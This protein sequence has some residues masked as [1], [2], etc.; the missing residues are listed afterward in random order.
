MSSSV[1]KT[2]RAGLVATAAML[3]VSGCA[4]PP[5][6]TTAAPV[7][8]VIQ[9]PNVVNVNQARRIL[10]SGTSA[11]AY[12][13]AVALLRPEAEKGYPDAQF[14]LG[15][16]FWEGKG[17]ER[18]PVRAVQLFE[19]ASSR[20]HV[21]AAML[22][23]A[24]YRDGTGVPRDPARAMA[25]LKVAADGGEADAAY[26]VAQAYH[27]GAGLRQDP[28]EAARYYEMAAEH[29]IIP[30]VVYVA[31][32]Y[33]TGNG[34]ELDPVWALRW[35]ERAANFGIVDSQVKFGRMIWSGEGLPV[36]QSEGM[37][38]LLIASEAGS[39]EARSTVPKF[40]R[41]MSRADFRAGKEA[42]DAWRAQQSGTAQVVDAATVR[43]VQAS[44][45][46]IGIPIAGINGR[47]DLATRDAVESFRDIREL[48]P[49][50]EIDLET[51]YAIRDFR[52]LTHKRA[53]EFRRQRQA[54]RTS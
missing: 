36:N 6:Q 5:K 8:P 27:N 7:R 2:V 51:V 1:L 24:A 15:R 39:K 28:K 38:W 34:V 48:G 25:F 50:G 43:F 37:K 44:F 40:R 29:G 13:Q 21:E 30:A 10:D 22:A 49:G 47:N 19:S 52:L 3:A 45:N 26:Q 33:E 16:A 23:H 31:E 42:A 20:G 32:A 17:V 9:K 4:E 11:A 46:Q 35:H 14:L 41:R 12:S 54:N 18:D 53:E